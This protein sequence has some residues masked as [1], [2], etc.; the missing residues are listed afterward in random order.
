MDLPLRMAKRSSSNVKEVMNEAIM[1][2]Q[3]KQQ[4]KEQKY[5]QVQWM[6]FLKCFMN[7]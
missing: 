1:D 4:W 6:L 5:G 7:I 3:K 2:I